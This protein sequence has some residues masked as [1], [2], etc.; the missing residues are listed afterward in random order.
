[1]W[2]QNF[3][4]GSCQTF[5][6]LSLQ[7]G[8]PGSCQLLIGFPHRRTLV[9]GDKWQH[10]SKTNWFCLDQAL[11]NFTAAPPRNWVT[12]SC[13]NLFKCNVFTGIRH[14]RP[15]CGAAVPS[16]TRSFF[17]YLLHCLSGVSRVMGYE[18]LQLTSWNTHTPHDFFYRAMSLKTVNSPG[19]LKTPPA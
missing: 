10:V 11:T 2:F 4:D 3:A 14:G 16:V 12:R 15:L 7:E 8:P 1:M 19:L 6:N 13:K 5:Q 18:L 17:V 9:K